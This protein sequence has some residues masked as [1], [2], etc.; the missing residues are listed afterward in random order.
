VSASVSYQGTGQKLLME[1]RM[2]T[3]PAALLLKVQTDNLYSLAY[4]FHAPGHD[5]L[6]AFTGRMGAFV[7]ADA[8]APG[9]SLHG[10]VTFS[11]GI[12]NLAPLSSLEDKTTPGNLSLMA[13]NDEAT[14]SRLAAGR[15][16][17]RSSLR[18]G[19]CP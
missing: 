5:A 2:L 8:Y 14:G 7:G 11:N 15:R 19:Q 6:A 9:Q 1:Q 3:P 10:I 17:D 16:Q 12:M 18:V 4:P 13:L